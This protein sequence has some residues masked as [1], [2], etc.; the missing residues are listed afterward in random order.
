MHHLFVSFLFIHFQVLYKDRSSHRHPLLFLVLRISKYSDIVS[1][2]SEPIFAIIGWNPCY[3][4]FRVFPNFILIIINSQIRIVGF[5]VLLIDH[6]VTGFFYFLQTYQIRELF[7][8][9]LHF[10][11][12]IIG[13]YDF[14][15]E[16]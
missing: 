13:M 5:Q 11:I 1:K 14:Y 6:C 12:I 4:E 3:Y 16:I 15:C 7:F 8:Y 9:E 2:I 10:I